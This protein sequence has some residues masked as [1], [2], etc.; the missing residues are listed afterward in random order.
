MMTSV[1]RSVLSD[2]WISY[3]PSPSDSQRT[4]GESLRFEITV[5][6]SATMNDE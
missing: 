3:E 5:T 1:P 4:A 6:R 2:D